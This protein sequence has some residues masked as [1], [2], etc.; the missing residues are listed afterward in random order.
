[1]RDVDEIPDESVPDPVAPPDTPAS[2]I[3]ERHPDRFDATLPYFVGMDFLSLPVQRESRRRPSES[4]AAKSWW[5]WRREQPGSPDARDGSRDRPAGDET[6]ETGKKR[7]ALAMP[8]RRTRLYDIHCSMK[9]KM[10]PFAGWQMPV[11][12]SSVGQEHAAVR[13]AAGLFDVSHMGCFEIAGPNAASFLDAVS[14]NYVRRLEDGASCYG[15][16]LD[17][18][19]CPI[20]DLL[21]YRRRADLYLL[22]VNAANEEKDWDWLNRVNKRQVAIDA[23]RPWIEL[24]APAELR[25][26]KDPAYGERQLRDLALQGPASLAILR[27]CSADARQLGQIQRTEL[28]ELELG[29][30]PVIAARTGY[31]GEEMGF[32][33]LV[34]PD[35]Q[36]DLW[37]MLL[38]RGRPLGLLACGLAARDST[39][40]EAGLP[41]YGHELAGPYDITPA[42]A[43]FGAYVKYHKPFFIGRDAL[44]R[45]DADRRRTVIRWRMK[46]KGVRRPGLGD[47]LIGSTGRVCGY[48]TSCSIDSLGLLSGLAVVEGRDMA[49]GMTVHVLREA[50]QMV[51][52]EGSSRLEIGD[53]FP[54]P[55]EASVLPRF[56]VR[57]ARGG[58]PAT[59]S[60]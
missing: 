10:V 26:L 41:L 45:R 12:Y 46:R 21:I 58:V 4:L 20:D 3:W 8:L 31:T 24:E 1:M 48:V 25:N 36:A 29:G 27:D 47:C 9:A 35:R 18:R 19:G 16:L 33:L 28:A 53:R 60:D 6:D 59:A 50:G 7:S 52:R 30:I 39:R 11:W 17:L 55:A 14:T 40:I 42:E 49:A 23:Q 32:E 51:V 44:L 38:E 22:V 13:E 2:E 37:N 54:L 43:G 56:P 15:F 5:D 34:H 57:S